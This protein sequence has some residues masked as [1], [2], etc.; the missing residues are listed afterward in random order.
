MK[1]LI[2]ELKDQ[3]C[4]ECPEIHFGFWNFWN[5]IEF[6]KLENKQQVSNQATILMH[7]HLKEVAPF[8]VDHKK[9]A[10]NKWLWSLEMTCRSP[11]SPWSSGNLCSKMSSLCCSQFNLSIWIYLN[12]TTHNF[13]WHWF[14][15]NSKRSNHSW[16]HKHDCHKRYCTILHHPT[17]YCWIALF[18]ITET[19]RPVPWGQDGSRSTIQCWLSK[20]LPS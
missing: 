6:W 3:S 2:D 15:T 13:R 7:G 12:S 8:M 14:N 17:R 1:R 20:Q 9:V 11:H 4:S 10:Q 19:V 16:N 5:P 18:T